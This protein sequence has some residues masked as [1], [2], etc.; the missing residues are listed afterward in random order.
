MSLGGS[1]IVKEENKQKKSEQG[2]QR[3]RGVVKETDENRPVRTER[4]MREGWR[5]RGEASM[6]FGDKDIDN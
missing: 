2:I 1:K 4:P 6:G 5:D 3:N